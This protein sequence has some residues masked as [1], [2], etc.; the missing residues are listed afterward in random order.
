[1]FIISFCPQFVELTL[2]PKCWN[3]AKCFNDTHHTIHV[4]QANYS[5]LIIISFTMS[6]GWFSPKHFF[7]LQRPALQFVQKHFSI[8]NDISLWADNW[9]DSVNCD[10]LKVLSNYADSHRRTKVSASLCGATPLMRQPPIIESHR[11][12]QAPASLD[13]HWW[14]VSFVGAQEHVFF[15]V[16]FFLG[17]QLHFPT[18]SSFRKWFSWQRLLL[19]IQ[20]ARCFFFFCIGHTNN[21]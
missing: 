10:K 11:G 5:L 1:M 20:T 3:E 19:P 21:H 14:V 15:F 13:S 8:L 16:V 7:F 6:R 4:T 18:T 12:E 17:C 2:K 9:R